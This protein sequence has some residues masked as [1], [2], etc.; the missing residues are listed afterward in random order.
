MKFKWGDLLAIIIIYVLWLLNTKFSIISPVF[1]SA[2]EEAVAVDSNIVDGHEYVD[3]G[4]PSGLKWATCNIGAEHEF[5][6]GNFFR[7]AD[8]VPLIDSSTITPYP[9]YDEIGYANYIVVPENDVAT[10]LWGAAWRMPTLDEAKELCEGCFWET[11]TICGHSV[12]IATSKYN[13]KKICIPFTDCYV[14]R[15]WSQPTRVSFNHLDEEPAEKSKCSWYWTSSLC[16]DQKSDSLAFS[17]EFNE[18]WGYPSSSPRTDF[19]PVRP[20]CR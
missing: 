17:F 10:L 6:T 20:V 3:L 7:W 12:W 15:P 4:L 1:N 19:H 14:D 11:D 13:R 8:T 9:P 2:P 16:R 5:S 18:Y